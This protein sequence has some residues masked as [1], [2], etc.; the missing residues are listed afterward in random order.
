MGASDRMV[1]NVDTP[2]TGARAIADERADFVAWLDR[3]TES[4]LDDVEPLGYRRTLSDDEIR[5]AVQQLEERF[6][7]R[8]RTWWPEPIADTCVLREEAFISGPG[9]ERLRHALES[10]SIDRVLEIREYGRSCDV[11][12]D[13]V[14]VTYNLAE[15]LVTPPDYSWMIYTSH[16][17]TVAFTE[18]DLLDRLRATWVELDQWR[19]APPSLR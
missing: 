12:L 7:V 5:V 16:E 19:W 11:D 8:G 9:T 17:S 2:S 1:D 14:D 10:L 15:V 18:G 13:L 3:V 4:D 6:D